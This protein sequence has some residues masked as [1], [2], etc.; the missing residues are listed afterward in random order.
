VNDALTG[1]SV[2]AAA[3]T[4]RK[5]SGEQG[6]VWVFPRYAPC[7]FAGLPQL[8]LGSNT[9]LDRIPQM[10][11]MNLVTRC[12]Y[13]HSSIF[14]HAQTILFLWTLITI[15]AKGTAAVSDSSNNNNDIPTIAS[16][17]GSTDAAFNH[18]S[19]DPIHTRVQNN[20]KD[21][22]EKR[23]ISQSTA[24]AAGKI[25]SRLTSHEMEDSLYASVGNMATTQQP[26]EAAD[27][28]HVERT[29]EFAQPPRIARIITIPMSA[30]PPRVQVPGSPQGMPHTIRIVEI[31]SSRRSLWQRLFRRRIRSASSFLF[32][33]TSP[34][35]DAQ[36]KHEHIS[37]VQ[38]RV[39]SVELQGGIVGVGEYYSVIELGGKPIRVQIDTG[40]STLAVPMVGCASCIKKTNRYVVRSNSHAR[41][42]KCYDDAC[43][44]DRCG[45]TC[46]ICS[47][48][49]S[50]CASEHPSECG[51]SLRYADGSSASGS[52]VSDEVRWGEL[53]SNVT[54]GGILSNSPNFERPEVDGILG[55]AYKS[56]AC[57]PSCLDPPFDVFVKQQ[58]LDDVFSICMSS[59]G[60]KLMLGGYKP[61]VSRSAAV[62]YVPLFL[63]QPARYYR[64]K[65]GGSLEIGGETVSMPNFR[66]AIVDT[67]TTLIVTS[68]RA[69]SAIKQ[70]LQGRYCDVPELC[71]ED[72]WFQ[73]GMCVS[74]SAADLSRLP[75]LTF[76]LDNDVGLTLAPTDYMLE[77]RRG[78]RTYRCVGLMGM[79]GIGGMVVLGNTLMQK[80]V[81]VYDRANSRLGFAEAA[82]NCG[83]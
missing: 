41:V 53:R 63:T 50:C 61:S 35:V 26:L 24:R 21:R 77:Y 33:N 72:S 57:N 82:P 56:L 25:V 29:L 74:L 20:H 44:P 2:K 22:A 62:Q 34:A 38:K 7:D 40:S 73:S 11:G 31:D 5:V 83:D 80:Y 4:R 9:H 75:P 59:H 17:P 6:R 54:F 46:A 47:S 19:H 8:A 36:T 65:L 71:G 10:L 68:T 66:T 58:L 43:T 52:L 16:S 23:F 37:G 30:V 70:H 48:K 76:R 55:M 67:G 3:V 15:N 81:T 64:I 60:G 78:T 12:R 13:R 28:P 14:I 18:L 69:F 45:A 1:A 79:D 27:Q 32:S 51:F 49:G 39:Y 42:V